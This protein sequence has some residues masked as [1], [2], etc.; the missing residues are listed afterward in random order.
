MTTPN[1]P[2]GWPL[3]TVLTTA[4]SLVPVL[5]R[6]AL[7]LCAAW[8]LARALARVVPVAARRIGL[9]AHAE[10][11]GLGRVLARLDVQMSA[12]D[13]LLRLLRV[14][15]WAGALGLMME[16]LGFEALSALLARALAFLP[17]A[18]L[19][20]CIMLA[21]L[22]LAE[23][24]SEVVVRVARR[25]EWAGAHLLGRVVHVGILLLGI[26]LAAEQLGLAVSL[27]RG[28]IAIALGG[29]ALAVFGLLGAGIEP[30]LGRLM[31][32]YYLMRSLQ[33]GETIALAG[34]TGTLVQFGAVGLVLRDEEGTHLI[35]YDVALRTPI[36]RRRTRAAEPPS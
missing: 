2:T 17:R 1:Y 11:L 15:V 24:A 18:L 25:G 12:S 3:D 4:L 34:H 32:R 16:S 30:M 7:I 36:E 13:A 27:L 21:A 29:I 35:P 14:A 8:L 20:L 26:S 19:A 22:L 10:R 23:R 33:P 9:D 28:L 6:L 31:A 5:G